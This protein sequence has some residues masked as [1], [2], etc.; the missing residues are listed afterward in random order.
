MTTLG[1]LL[2][3]D[4]RMAL[5][6]QRLLREQSL[7]KIAFILVFATGLVGG[8]WAL[9]LEGFRFLSALGG[10]GLMLVSRL[11]ALFFLGL[12]WMLILSGAV[13]AYT[14]FYRSEETAFLLLKPVPIGELVL[15]KFAQSSFYDSWAFFFTI[16]PFVGAYAWHE[17]L[18]LFFSVW[19]FVFAVPLVLL[20][21]GIGALA[22]L[23]LARWMPRGRWLVIGGV[24]AFAVAFVWLSRTMAVAAAEP[25]EPALLLTRLVPGLRVASNPLWPS[26]WIA[27]G[28][29]A[30]TRG[31][32]GRGFMLWGVLAANV[33]M[34]GLMVESVGRRLFVPGWQRV[35]FAGT[36]AARRAALFRPLER[37]LGRLPSDV[38]GLVLKDLR[39]FC[40]DPAQWSQG[41]IFF[42]LLALY[43]LNLR[44]LRYHLLPQEWRNLIAFLNVFSVSAVMC[45]FGSRFVY[46]Q[47]SLEGHGF[48]IIGLS[49]T[50]MRRVLATKFGLA[51]AAM[52]VVSA[53]LMCLS[54]RMLAVPV[55]VRLV[56]MAIAVAMSFAISGLSTGLGAIFMDRKQQNPAAI[57]SG[58]G[59]TLN[60][61]LSLV[62]LCSVIAPFGTVFHLHFIGHV[63]AAELPRLLAFCSAWLVA[64]TAV[65]VRTPL[66]LGARSLRAQEY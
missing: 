15:Y 42:G 43:F 27:E 56:A 31:Q 33:A 26:W 10:M 3:K 30:L 4:L 13:T 7:F 29:M 54:T 58:F 25:D 19:T 6:V 65:A 2:R 17:R 41:V 45:S 40:R 18:P 63:P 38:R 5:G 61:V 22:C 48:W 55:A 57:V 8:L 37:A 20:C 1:A 66:A 28:I 24:V 16:V 62:Y 60:L 44:S 34:V 53:G 35:H 51:S 50:T 52:V 9:F 21:T 46:P 59:G 12:L 14:T 47:L 36:Q 49:P 32:W 11:F 23:A 39:T 64:V